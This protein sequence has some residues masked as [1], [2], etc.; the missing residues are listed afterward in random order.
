[1]TPQA[2]RPFLARMAGARTGAA[3]CAAAFTVFVWDIV[4]VP[5]EREGRVS[6]LLPGAR[7]GRPGFDMADQDF[8]DPGTDAAIRSISMRSPGR[9]IT[10]RPPTWNS[11]V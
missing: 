6:A 3:A 7:T 1:M 2:S 11:S 4:P 8:S 9:P 5:F 10:A